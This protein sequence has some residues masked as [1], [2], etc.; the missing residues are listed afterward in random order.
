[1]YVDHDKPLVLWM[2]VVMDAQF[3]PSPSEYLTP[4]GAF[5]SLVSSTRTYARPGALAARATANSFVAAVILGLFVLAAVVS[6][7]RKDITPRF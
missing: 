1:M 6:A 5:L 7:A 4:A 3:S 2:M